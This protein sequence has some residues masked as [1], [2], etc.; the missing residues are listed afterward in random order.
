MST[1]DAPS[2]TAR[3]VEPSVGVDAVEEALRLLGLPGAIGAASYLT[4]PNATQY[5]LLVDVLADEQARRL[6]G[7][8]HDE[9]PHLVA[10]RVQHHVRSE[11]TSA[12]LDALAD[13]DAL[14]RRM[15][16]LVAWR[17]CDTWQ[18]QAHTEADFLRNRARY[19]LTEQGAAVNALAREIDA[20][21][22]TRTS[23]AVLAPPIL[24]A[25]LES[26]VAAFVSEPE[27]ASTS[28]AQ[29]QTTILDMARTA[30]RWQARLAAGLSGAPDPDK[31]DRL[32]QTVVD[33]VDMWGAGVD[34][35]SGRIAEAADALAAFPDEA[36]RG[37]AFARL[38]AAADD[39]RVA[40]V[41]AELRG[42]LGTVQRWFTGPRP[43]ARALRLQM[44]DAVAPL[45]RG[46]RTL[47]AVGGAISRSADLL[48]L[49]TA[50]E[51]ATD[52]DAAWRVWCTATGL[53]GARH[54]GLTAPPVDA[55]AETSTW[56][57]P[58]VPIERRLRLQ[59]PR[60]LS[61]RAP[62]I[63]DT[64]AARSLARMEAARTRAR[65]AEAESR[66]IARSGTTLSSWGEIDTVEAELL[67][68]LIQIARAG[69]PD[70]RGCYRGTSS[71]GRRTLRLTPVTPAASAVLHLPA[72]RLVLDDA[73]VEIDA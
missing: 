2:S 69:A 68:D 5:R 3:V 54:L 72:G 52:D 42:T 27:V 64:S 32:L 45:L 19:Q 18:D 46:H 9:L 35:Y 28:L 44:R 8:P 7:V 10:A 66:L 25:E 23:S 24:A 62:R 70:S 38:G 40:E 58:P 4:S 1:D 63:R 71:D 51:T 73:L 61:G 17:T 59:G 6:T 36:W 60:A 53:Y 47:L 48:R 12:V 43:Q 13:P 56:D 31:V 65:T 26:A 39:D 15:D 55:P 21:H 16:Q 29:V 67:L 41:V 11:S 30:G 20:G 50:L 22:D 57:A 34:V 49:A 14:A 37:P 33:Y